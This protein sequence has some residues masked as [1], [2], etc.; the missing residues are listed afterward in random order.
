MYTARL[1]SAEKNLFPITES[2]NKKYAT[3]VTLEIEN[4]MEKKS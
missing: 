3:D 1:S 2:A 4:E